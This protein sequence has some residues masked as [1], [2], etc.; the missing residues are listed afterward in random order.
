MI[1]KLSFQ[2]QIT[3]HLLQHIFHY[4]KHQIKNKNAAISW[5]SDHPLI[6]DDFGTVNRPGVNTDVKL[7]VTVTL[8]GKSESKDF[9]CYSFRTI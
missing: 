4:H 2:I 1:F 3:F 8:G 6:I 7:T 5:V 9:L